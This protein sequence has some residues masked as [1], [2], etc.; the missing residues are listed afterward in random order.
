MIPVELKQGLWSR[1]DFGQAGD[2]INGFFF[3]RLPFAL[4]FALNE[5]AHATDLLN[6]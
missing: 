4:L 2:E 3:Y 5:A 6:G 1:F